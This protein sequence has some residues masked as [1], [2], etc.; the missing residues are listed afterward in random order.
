MKI[1]RY[2][3]FP[4]LDKFSTQWWA[5]DTMWSMIEFCVCICI[6]SPHPQLLITALLPSFSTQGWAIDTVWPAV[7]KGALLVQLC[8]CVSRQT[9][10]G[11][12]GTKNTFLNSS[13]Q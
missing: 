11:Q 1:S 7:A 12:F 4:L 2:T 5:N 3:V 8:V 13:G 9:T 6:P 10:A